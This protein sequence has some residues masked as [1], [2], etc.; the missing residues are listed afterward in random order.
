MAEDIPASSYST[1][2]HCDESGFICLLRLCEG[3]VSVAMFYLFAQG[4]KQI[5]NERNNKLS[6]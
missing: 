6:K 2:F 3:V 4:Y 1:I 5:A